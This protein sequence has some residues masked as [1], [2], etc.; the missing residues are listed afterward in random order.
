MPHTYSVNGAARD[1][2][3]GLTVRQVLTAE[4]FDGDWFAVALD[5]AV[6]PSSRWT[7]TPVP[8]NSELDVI[9]PCQGG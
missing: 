5:G 4:D 9:Q 2:Q 8:A 1:W 3:P 6:V 7:V